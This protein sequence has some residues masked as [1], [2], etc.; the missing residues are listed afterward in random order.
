MRFVQAFSR[1]CQDVS[2][3]EELYKKIVILRMIKWEPNGL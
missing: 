2:L 3:A 1:F